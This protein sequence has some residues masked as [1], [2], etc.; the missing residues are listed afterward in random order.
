MHRKKIMT[1]A[2]CITL[3]AS[4]LTACGGG[5]NGKGQAGSNGETSPNSSNSTDN[6]YK[7]PMTISLGFWDA[8]AEIANIEKD[9]IAKQ[10]LE[11][12]N[13]TL[14]PVNLSWDDYTQKIQMWYFR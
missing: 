4:V 12:F 13:I 9:P 11:K 2:L 10:V 3:L 8:D 14:K 5:N 6:P 7:D 1:L